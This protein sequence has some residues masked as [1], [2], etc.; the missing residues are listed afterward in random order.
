MAEINPFAA[1]QAAYADRYVSQAEADDF[2]EL[3][4][5]LLEAHGQH[6]KGTE[7]PYLDSYVMRPTY[8]QL[9]HLP[10]LSDWKDISLVFVEPV[11]EDP[12]DL[13]SPSL[14]GAEF[15][16]YLAQPV[17]MQVDLER[18]V[19]IIVGVTA[20][21]SDVPKFSSDLVDLLREPD[22]AND[23]VAGYRVDK[24]LKIADDHIDETLENVSM[25]LLRA[26]LEEIQTLVQRIIY[27]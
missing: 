5:A 13:N 4:M 14:I 12:H 1:E 11:L 25:P 21:C 7:Y 27:S 2:V 23:V 18:D 16:C 19:S 20:A 24:I 10:L 9:D 3:T 15:N 22:I 26:L 8:D 17:D 6:L